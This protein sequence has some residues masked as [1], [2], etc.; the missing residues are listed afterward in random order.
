MRYVVPVSLLQ[1]A[2]FVL[3]GVA[4]VR[5]GIAASCGTRGKDAFCALVVQG[6]R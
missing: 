2:V 3:L 4:L 1:V 5:G 6:I